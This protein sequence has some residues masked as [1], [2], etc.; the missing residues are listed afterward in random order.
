M[1]I[2]TVKIQVGL[3]SGIVNAVHAAHVETGHVAE[4]VG[5]ANA[6]GPVGVVQVG[7][8]L[9][10]GTARL[11]TISNNH[12]VFRCDGGDVFGL[13]GGHAECQDCGGDCKDVF[14]HNCCCFFVFVYCLNF[15][16]SIRTYRKWKKLHR[17]CFFSSSRLYFL[18]LHLVAGFFAI[19]GHN[20]AGDNHGG[21]GEPVDGPASAAGCEQF[22]A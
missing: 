20:G 10:T 16:S 3:K 13:A 6:A 11:A 9:H 22:A 21:I 19:V 7:G 14:L 17:W 5:K 15:F 4:E 18:E 12:N 8:A 2:Y 1:G